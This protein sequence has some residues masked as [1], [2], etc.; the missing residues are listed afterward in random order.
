MSNLVL[1]EKLIN[2]T[3]IKT[4]VITVKR[5][6]VNNMGVRNWYS[7]LTTEG[8]FYQKWAMLMNNTEEILFLLKEGDVLEIDYIN[9]A[10]E[11]LIHDTFESF[12]R[13]VI[14]KARIIQLV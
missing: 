10:A 14:L 11:D 4:K 1:N 8:E 7:V 12:T 6:A 3:D 2:E 13:K 9:D 5:C